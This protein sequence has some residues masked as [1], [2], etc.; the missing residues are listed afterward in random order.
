MRNGPPGA[1]KTRLEFCLSVPPGLRL[2]VRKL[3]LTLSYSQT[4]SRSCWGTNGPI[5]FPGREIKYGFLISQKVFLLIS[6][7]LSYGAYPRFL[8]QLPWE[9]C[10][11]N[12][13]Q[14]F[15]ILTLLLTAVWC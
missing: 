9:S 4:A 3:T 15:K 11:P 1:F 7:Q 10:V 5:H 6:L 8:P 2:R 12:V 14:G 13:L